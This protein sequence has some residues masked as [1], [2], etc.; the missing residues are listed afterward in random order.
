[1]GHPPQ[2]LATSILE[3][4]AKDTLEDTIGYQCIGTTR[5]QQKGAARMPCLTTSHLEQGAHCHWVLVRGL[6]H[7]LVCDRTQMV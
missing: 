7:I 6:E 3:L 4:L 2:R 5:E 1:M